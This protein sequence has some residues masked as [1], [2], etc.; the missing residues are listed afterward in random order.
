MHDPDGVTAGGWGLTMTPRDMA[1]LGLLYLN[2]G[3]WNG[4]RI[5]SES[6]VRQSVKRTF[7][8]YGYMWWQFEKKG[9]AVHAAMGDGGNMICWVPDRSLVVAIA[10][11]FVPEAKNRWLMVRDYILPAVE[12]IWR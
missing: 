4:A 6:W 12:E 5:I 3:R 2:M 1:R 7:S 11:G 9:V 10:S 8:R